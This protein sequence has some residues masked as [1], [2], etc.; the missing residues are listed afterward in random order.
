MAGDAAKL[1]A[2]E[3][4]SLTTRIMSDVGHR[5]RRSM[6]ETQ[7]MAVNAEA[8]P[9]RRILLRQTAFGAVSTRAIERI[10]RTVS[11]QKRLVVG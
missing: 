4:I 10:P 8:A 3:I 9:P 6:L 2:L 1:K 11:L 5:R 7:G